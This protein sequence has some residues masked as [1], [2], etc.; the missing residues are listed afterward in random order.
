MKKKKIKNRERQIKTTAD[1]IKTTADLKALKKLKISLG[2]IIAVFA[3]ILYAQSIHH[4]YTLDDHPVID[5]NSITKTGFSGI[6]TILKTDYWYGF[7]HDEFRG[8]IYRPIPLII[9]AIAWEFS[10]NNP[11]VYHLINVLFYA[12]TCL[13]L[14]LVLCKLFKKQNLLFPFICALLYTAHPIHT[15]VVN[16]IKCLDEIFC[17]LFGIIAIWFQLKYLSSK[18]IWSFILI[19]I[20]FF[21]ALLSKETGI[22][23]LVIIPLIIFFF[24][25]TSLKKTGST[26]LLL[27][28]ITGVWL[29]IRMIVFKDLPPNPGITTSV[30]N[31]SL[32][33]AP[34]NVSKYATIFYILLRYII[35]LIFPHPLT[36]DYNFAEIQIQTLGDPAGLIGIIVYL[37]LGIYSIINFRKKTIVA[38][39]ILFFLITLAPVSNIFFLGGSTMAERFMYIPS[40]G[41]CIIL[42]YFL[43]KLTKTESIKSGFKNLFQFFTLNQRVFFIVLAIS[44]LYYI[45]TTSRNKDWK[46]NITIFSHDVKISGN[47][48]RANQ[49]LGS[50]LMISVMKSPDKQT[51]TDTFNL[52]KTYLKRAL[53]IYPEFYTP[54]SHLGVIY[55]Y[56]KNFDSAYY[57]LKKG[58]ALMPNDIDLNFN[59]GLLLINLKKYDEAIKVLNHTIELTST[60]EDA[61]YNLAALYQ[62]TGDYDKALLYYSKV[63]GLNPNNANAYY[64]SGV[65]LKSKGDTL[66]GN[67]FINKAMSLGYKPN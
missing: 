19:G 15:E 36:C 54:L 16:N 53:E 5:E 20:S 40:L 44:L 63:I 51:H 8:P 52:A 47:S 41:F 23:F 31:N 42:T 6:P 21:L 48:A 11:H 62:N 50:A 33:A 46:D 25:D 28:A 2:I 13:L 38:F 56:E 22:T 7:G 58:L 26:F 30:L 9:F 27:L 3:F 18:S 24:T 35:L 66:K 57:Y 60:H 12:L 39:G 49:I 45:K 29:I 67:E 17:F 64:N 37:G 61:Y 34:D 4:D 1:L 10:P 55:M 59:F 43:I 14:F 32:N 65:L